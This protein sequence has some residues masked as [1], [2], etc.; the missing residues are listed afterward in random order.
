VFPPTPLF[1][2]RG[3]GFDRRR[4]N[5]FVRA[6]FALL[7]AL[8]MLLGLR[9]AGAAGAA[10]MNVVV[11]DT[12]D[13]L[14]TSPGDGQCRTS[15]G[16]CTLRAAIQETNAISGADIVQLPPG[17]YELGIAP[18]NQ[19]DVT[20]G[21]LDITDSLAIIGAGASATIVDGGAPP[22]G[23]PVRVRGLDRLFEVLADG[24]AVEFSG[25][26]FS[27][28]YAA[29]Y[30]GAIMNN[31]TATITVTASTLTGNVA[32]KVGG[33]ID[34]HLGGAVHVQDSTFSN[35]VSFESG[36]ALNNNRGGALSVVNSSIVS[37]SAADIGLDES[38]RA[39]ERR[40]QTTE[41]APSLS[42]R[43][44]SPRIER[45]STAAPSST[46]PAK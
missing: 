33:A 21:D 43:P 8:A 42:M 6:A 29:E 13:R 38:A 30:G 14:D 41:P 17:T 44:P 27:D 45:K 18:L 2:A 37:N 12:A 46:V 3:V 1:A 40:F 15:A 28:G 20:T 9:A 35:N 24:G 22:A 32:D 34:N 39:R 5:H 26:T 25:L 16:T 19:N 31:S 10:G 7:F 36:S 4:C 11:N 23:A